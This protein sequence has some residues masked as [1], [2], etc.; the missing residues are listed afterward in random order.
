MREETDREVLYVLNVTAREEAF[1]EYVEREA[2]HDVLDRFVLLQT[3][4]SQ[5]FGRTSELATDER[6]G[7]PLYAHRGGH[8]AYTRTNHG[9]AMRALEKLSRLAGADFAHCG[10][11]AGSHERASEAVIRNRNALVSTRS[12][13]G[14]TNRSVPVISGGINPMNIHENMYEISYNPP[15]TD[16]AFMIGSGIYAHSGGTLDGIVR[17]IAANRQAIQAAVAGHDAEDVLDTHGSKYAAMREWIK[18][19]DAGGV[20]SD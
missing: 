18:A 19:E 1:L 17:G 4:I 16:L 5:G 12:A 6:Y 20:S 15:E 9:I 7:N 10:A 2:I 13:W 14:R 11:V 8:A 3:V